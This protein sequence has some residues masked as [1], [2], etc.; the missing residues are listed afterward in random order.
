MIGELTMVLLAAAGGHWEYERAGEFPDPGPCDSA[1]QNGEVVVAG[2]RMGVWQGRASSLELVVPCPAQEDRP[3]RVRILDGRDFIASTPCGLYRLDMQGGV[4]RLPHPPEPGALDADGSGRAVVASGG[5]LWLLDPEGKRRLGYALP[6]APGRLE[7]GGEWLLV[8]GERRW[9]LGLSGFHQEEL[10][11]WGWHSLPGGDR[12][13]AVQPAGRVLVR[14]VGEPVGKTERLA[15]LPAERVVAVRGDL[16]VTSLRWMRVGERQSGNLP[17]VAGR[18]VPVWGKQVPW[19]VV[20][21]GVYRPVAAQEGDPGGCEVP[22]LADLYTAALRAQ[23]LE[24]PEQPSRFSGWL[25][26]VKVSV[27]GGQTRKVRWNQEGAWDFSAG[28]YLGAFVFLTWPLE[29]TLVH[30]KEG[31]REDLRAGIERERIRLRERLA[32]LRAAFKEHCRR[33]DRQALSEIRARIYMLTTEIT[34]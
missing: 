15:L 1:A 8:E 22:D 32:V 21:G 4:T 34:R 20:A 29:R 27:F 23:G 28:R 24:L 2:C 30:E 9:L 18:A 33:G 3:N 11:G 5:D 17:A 10:S 19:M 16:V 25:P 7:L 26:E 31:A 6:E 13:L 12:L 14:R